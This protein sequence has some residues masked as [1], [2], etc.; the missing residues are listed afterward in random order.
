MVIAEGIGVTPEGVQP[1]RRHP[2]GLGQPVDRIP[3]HGEGDGQGR[4]QHIGE[5]QRGRMVVVIVGTTAVSAPLIEF[6]DQRRDLATI[7][8]RVEDR[9]AIGRQG[10]GSLQKGLRGDGLRVG[11]FHRFDGQAPLVRAEV[12]RGHGNLPLPGGDPLHH[13]MGGHAI[14]PD[15][16]RLG[17]PPEPHRRLEP[18]E[19]ARQQIGPR[20]GLGS[21]ALGQAPQAHLS[22]GRRGRSGWF[23]VTV[24]LVGTDAACEQQQHRS[25]PTQPSH[26]HSPLIHEPTLGETYEQIADPMMTVL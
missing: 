25:Q 20:R 23:I 11:R 7:V 21:G 12:I 16:E 6:T 24:P 10:D 17:I 5:M 9:D 13:A 18:D 8:G 14:R 4:T 3:V 1:H 19:G 2:V 15:H 22:R 26:P